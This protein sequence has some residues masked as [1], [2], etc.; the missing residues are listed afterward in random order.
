[1]PYIP[2]SEIKYVSTPKEVIQLG[3]TGAYGTIISDLQYTPNGTEGFDVFEALKRVSCRKILWTGAAQEKE[4]QK[5]A[6]DLGVELLDK[7]E[8]GTLVGAI[9][10]KAPLKKGGDVLIY[11]N[12]SKAMYAAIAQ[13]VSLF[14]GFRRSDSSRIIVSNDLKKELQTGKYGLVIDTS[15]FKLGKMQTGLQGTVAHDM[16]YLQLSE[17]PKVVCLYDV[18]TVVADI[19]THCNKFFES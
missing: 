18:S 16:K 7:D 17:I 14:D 19:V 12:H 3:L 6:N 4:V 13:V 8:L 5:K 2:N 9:V 10:C 1:M 11:N 15:T